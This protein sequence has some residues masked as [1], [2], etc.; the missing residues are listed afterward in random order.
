MLG[1]FENFP[2]VIQ[3]YAQFSYGFSPAKL[4]VLVVEA[5]GRLNSQKENLPPEGS[6]LGLTTA[7]EVGVAESNSF[8]FLREEEVER[9]KRHLSKGKNDVLDFFVHIVY[10]HNKSGGKSAPLWGD[11][12][13]VRFLFQERG[14]LEIQVSHFKGTRRLPLDELIERLVAKIN[15]EAEKR[16]LKPLKLIELKSL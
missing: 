8:I 13:F 12:N 16:R 7:Y 9:I 15:E 1:V 2:S 6:A 4:Q 10:R 11:F 5:M 3:A 14:S